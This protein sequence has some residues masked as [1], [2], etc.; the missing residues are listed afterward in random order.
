MNYATSYTGADHNRGYAFQEIFGVPI[1]E[2]VDR[3]AAEGRKLTKGTRTC[4]PQIPAAI[5]CSFML[6]Q[7]FAVTALRNCRYLEVANGVEFTPDTVY[8]VGEE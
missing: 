5:V 6:D 3:F 2:A 1:P 8:E 4:A 7:A